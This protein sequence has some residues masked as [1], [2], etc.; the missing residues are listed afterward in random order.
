M[1][2]MII[3]VG[4]T[5]TQIVKLAATSKLLEDVKMYAIDS[6]A[7]S[8]DIDMINRIT[9]IPIISDSKNGSGRSRERGAAMYEFHEDNGEFVDMYDDAVNSKAPVLVI[10]SAAGGTGSGS[11]VPLCKSLIAENVQV[12][13]IIICPNEA[14]PEAFHLNT[15]DLFIE[16]DE[17]G[18]TTYAV[19]QNTRRYSDYALINQDVVNMIEI[20][21]GRRYDETELDTIDDSDLDVIL[22]TPGRF[23]AVSAEAK[24]AQTLSKELA[25]KV[26]SGYQP[27]WTDEEASNN[28]L[29]LAC[30]LKSIFAKDDFD[31]VF[32]EI[33]KRLDAGNMYDKYKN[34]VNDN[35]DGK[36]SATLIV[37][38]LPRAAVKVIS[39]EYKEAESLGS[40]LNKSKRPSFMNRKKKTITD[41]NGKPKFNWQK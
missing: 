17:I 12:I 19:F 2:N 23:I 13:P 30:G 10:T 37:A 9:V 32:E 21:F 40:G 38:G 41:D 14:D 15:N 35:N 6:V 36:S 20:V 34:I 1:N 31:A 26:F 7:A 16:L 24:D 22:N 39:S 4:N 27:A 3:G 33:D 28:T 25:R 18:I 5:G 11:V 29:L 8:V